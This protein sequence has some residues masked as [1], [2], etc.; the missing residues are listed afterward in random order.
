MF[1][2]ED[3]IRASV[4]SRG[5]GDVYKGPVLAAK[6]CTNIYAPL[7]NRLG[8]GQLKWELEDYCFRYLHPT[9]YKRIAKLLHE[10]RL[11]REHYIEE[12][13]GHLRAE[14]KAEGVKA[15]VYGRPKHIY[16]IWRKMQKKNLAFDE[17]FDVRAVRIVAERLQDCY[18]ALGIVHTHYR[19]LPDEFD[20]YVANPKPN[21]YQSIH[22]VVLGPGGKTVEIQIR[23]KQ[24]HEDAELGVAAHWKY[25][26]GAA[27]GGAPPGT[28]GGCPHC[29]SR[30]PTAGL[31]QRCR[32]WTR[33]CPKWNSG[34]PLAG[35]RLPRWTPCAASTCWTGSH[36]QRCLSARCTAC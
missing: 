25:K 8:I 16:S 27:A 24:M 32:A 23:T 18:A 1:Q 35:W 33:C 19:H 10:R 4:A 3:G 31:A 36:G 7:A 14:M 28:A 20:D 26:E 11:D 13:V 6:E 9:E 22:T 17:L 34:C 21:G 5:L 30:R 2:A 12:F 15:E 29:A